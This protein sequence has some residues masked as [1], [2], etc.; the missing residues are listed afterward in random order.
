MDLKKVLIGLMVVILLALAALN[1]AQTG[2]YFTASQEKSE[3][4]RIGYGVFLSNLPVF[5]AAEKGFFES[6]NLKVE[7]IKF[8]TVQEI[9]NALV[10]D[11]ID[12]AFP[13]GLEMVI[14]TE[15]VKPKAQMIF[16]AKVNTLKCKYKLSCGDDQALIVK[17][18]SIIDINQLAGKKIGIH[19]STSQKLLAQ[20][21]KEKV[22]PNTTIYFVEVPIFMH[23][24]VLEKGNVDAVITAEPVIAV[25]KQKKIGKILKEEIYASTLYDPIPFIV[26]TISTKA[27]NEKPKESQK[28]LAAYRKAVEYIHEQPVEARKTAAKY[29][30][31]GE[32]ILTSAIITDQQTSEEIDVK[33]L[34]YFQSQ[35]AKHLNITSNVNIKD[36]LIK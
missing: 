35:I 21:W 2:G 13:N 31:L 30:G 8:G 1:F 26:Y 5:V 29:V 10:N 22:F 4:I 14:A 18:E 25:S 9:N 12:V 27:L 33:A 7:L 24:Q 34:E 17:N 36:L 28:F 23:L 19:P 16:G 20:M 32:E 15:N 6:E 3:V 11:A